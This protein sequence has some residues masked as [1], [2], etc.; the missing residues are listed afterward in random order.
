MCQGQHGE[1]TTIAASGLRVEGL[2]LRVEGLGLRI[3]VSG[4]GVE[5][6]VHICFRA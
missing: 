6:L 1:C 5:D 3:E 2:G 4:F